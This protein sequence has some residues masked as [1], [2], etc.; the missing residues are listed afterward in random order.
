[1]NRQQILLVIVGVLLLVKFGFGYINDKRVESKELLETKYNRYIKGK[2]L[3]DTESSIDERL[4]ELN[5]SLEKAKEF[6]PIAVSA[7]DARLDVQRRINTLAE[8]SNL[9][10]ESVEWLSI[11]EGQPEKAIVDLRFI[12]EFDAMIKFHLML[13]ELGLVCKRWV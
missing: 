1:M 7:Q 4:N 3:L 13:E 5:L 2:R 8:Q 10:V 12:G 9:T 11:E 6:Y